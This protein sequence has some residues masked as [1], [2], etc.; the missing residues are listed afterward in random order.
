MIRIK[1]DSA[2]DY[3]DWIR[4]NTMDK[5]IDGGR[6]IFWLRS[7]GNPLVNS[8]NIDKYINTYKE[9]LNG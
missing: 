5:G 6:F 8:N 2:R 1:K 3:V 7:N 4:K 9:T